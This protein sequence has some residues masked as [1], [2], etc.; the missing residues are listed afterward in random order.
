MDTCE[1]EIESVVSAVT[2]GQMISG[3][4]GGPSKSRFHQEAMVIA[5]VIAKKLGLSPKDFNIRSNKAGPAVC[6]EVVLHTINVYVQFS[7]F[8]CG[9]DQPGILYRMC[10][11]LRDYSGGMNQYW[12]WDKLKDLDAFVSR[13][14]T[15]SEKS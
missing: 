1:R 4:G 11:G 7:Q 14:K 13:L 10:N 2:G 9:P 5:K 8:Y 12:K 6:G 3:Y 15:I